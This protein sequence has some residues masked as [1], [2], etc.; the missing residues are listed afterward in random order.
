MARWPFFIL[1]CLLTG[2][3]HAQWIQTLSLSNNLGIT[4]AFAVI[5]TNLFAGTS[6]NSVYRSTDNGVSWTAVN[7]GLTDT[8]ITSLAVIG[9]NLFAGTSRGVF[10]STDNGTS[11]TAASTGLQD[12]SIYA[13]AVIDTNLFAGNKY[14]VYRSTDNGASWAGAYAG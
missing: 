7:S 3:L 14:G 10:R 5:G 1:F 12:T 4:D 2:T 6:S 9:T 8:N 11:W 13:L